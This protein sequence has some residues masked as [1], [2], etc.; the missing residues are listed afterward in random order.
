MCADVSR[1]HYFHAE[2][3]SLGG[4]IDKP[5]QKTMPPQASS[6][7]PPV[8]GHVTHRTEAFHFEGIFSC[9][10]SHTRVSGRHIEE[11]GSASTVATSVIEG[12]NI[13]E[14]ITAE[15][16][17]AKVSMVHPA[18]GGAPIVSFTGSRFEGL[19]IGGC[20]ASLSLNASLLEGGQSVTAKREPITWPIFH[21]TGKQQADKLVKSAKGEDGFQWITDRYGW[22]ASESKPNGR[23]LCSLVDGVHPAV[24]GRSFGHVLHIPNFGKVILGEI[25]AYPGSVRICMIRAELGSPASGGMTMAM[26][27]VNGDTFP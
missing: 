12:L 3:N 23:A 19:L 10:S 21:K 9:R 6:S 4:F 7:L 15:R 13:A 27:V 17:V 24:P 26:S 20:D 5:L 18:K 16:V 8:G 25:V 1:T 11:D 22:L 14:V 2:A